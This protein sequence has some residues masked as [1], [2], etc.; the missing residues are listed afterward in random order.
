MN[1]SIPLFPLDAILF[2]GTRSV[3]HIFEPRYRAMLADILE[4]DREFGLLPPGEDGGA[5]TPGTL[6][7]VARVETHQPLPDD[8]SLVT[9]IGGK[10]FIFGDSVAT[11]APYLLGSVVE[12]DDDPGE[13]DI[14]A[15]AE[16]ALRRLGERCRAALAELTDGDA[17]G[18]WADDGAA[19]TF[20]VAS[21]VP[22]SAGQAR[23]LLAIRSAAG[24]A[25]VLLQVL[26]QI[27]PE[28]EGRAA[29]HT[30]ASTNGKGPHLPELSS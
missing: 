30:R 29:V 25:D 11:T 9:V 28:L 19:L 17:N 8:R 7:C 6:G 26:P 23:Q 15:D 20:E 3:L 14:P 21:V 27:V 12:F 2:P 10:R 16:E 24:R 18:N 1:R 4:G 5:P 22:W 13:H